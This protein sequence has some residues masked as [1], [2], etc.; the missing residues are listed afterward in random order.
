MVDVGELPFVYR[1]Q[2]MR[3]LEVRAGRLNLILHD[4][5]NAAAWT[6]TLQVFGYFGMRGLSGPDTGEGQ[7]RNQDK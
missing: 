5:I 1:A 6:D 3:P 7:P 2:R 4:Y